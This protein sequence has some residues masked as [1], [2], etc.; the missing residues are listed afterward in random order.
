V[1]IEDIDVLLEAESD[2]EL[3]PYLKTSAVNRIRRTDKHF[4][5]KLRYAI[6]VEVSLGNNYTL[7]NHPQTLLHHEHIKHRTLTTNPMNGGI[8]YHQKPPAYCADMDEANYSSCTTATP[9]PKI[10]RHMIATELQQINSQPNHHH[11]VVASPS[12]QAHNHNQR[13]PSEHIY[14]SIDSDYSTLDCENLQMVEAQFQQNQSVPIN[15]IPNM[16]AHR[17]AAAGTWRNSNVSTNSSNN[18][19]NPNGHHVQAYLV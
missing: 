1:I 18:I 19:P 6:P 16:A 9:S 3:L 13:P 15:I 14:S 4:W 11:F 12:Q 2:I 5:E 17:A 8:V 10:S 7:T